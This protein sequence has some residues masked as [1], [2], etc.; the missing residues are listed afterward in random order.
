MGQARG[1]FAASGH[2]IRKIQARLVTRSFGV[3][4]SR[5]LCPESHAGCEDIAAHGLASGHACL[6]L[7]EIAAEA[8]DSLLPNADLLFSL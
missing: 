8:L 6:D 4:E 1:A 3:C 5:F 2:K 7:R